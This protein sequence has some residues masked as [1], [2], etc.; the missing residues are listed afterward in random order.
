MLKVCAEVITGAGLRD[1]AGFVLC[2]VG[3]ELLPSHRPEGKQ[4]AWRWE[5]E[6][7]IPA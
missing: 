3:M 6:R 4:A 5:K 1:G 7:K 2:A